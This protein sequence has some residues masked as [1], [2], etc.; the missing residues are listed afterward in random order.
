[1]SKPI[2]VVDS[3]V[4]IIALDTTNDEAVQAR[5]T[6]I[7]LAFERLEKMNA[8][9]VV[10][11]PVVAELC[12]G[13]PGSDV[14]RQIMRAFLGRLR[15]HVLDE[16]AALVAGDISRDTLKR[17]EGRERG[18]VKFD[19]LIFG[20]A[21]HIGAKWL[22]TGNGKDYRKCADSIKSSVEIVVATDPPTGQQ[23]LVSILVPQKTT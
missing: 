16:D 1:V 17:R 14:L 11:A 23:V 9:Y 7:G 8:T 22:V 20:I 2:A 18:A 15:I 5:R 13:A 10:P 3:D 21:H 19:S 4:I 12:G 6:Y